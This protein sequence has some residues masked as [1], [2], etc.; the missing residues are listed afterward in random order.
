MQTSIY[1]SRLIGRRN[2]LSARLRR[3]E[4]D[5]DIP[6]SHDDDD[7]ATEREDEE[8]LE[9]LGEAGLAELR[10]IEAALARIDNGT[11]GRCAKCGRPMSEERLDAVPHAALCMECIAENTKRT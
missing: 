3:I 6:S 10:A 7:R 5:L 11:Y 4:G 9:S 1:R 2:E 8:V